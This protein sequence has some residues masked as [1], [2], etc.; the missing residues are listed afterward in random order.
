LK[1]F[2]IF[3]IF[4]TKTVAII[5]GGPAGL[6]AAEE[7][8]SAGH[9]VSV[10]DAMPS[11]GRKFLLAGVGGMNITHAEPAED[12]RARYSANSQFINTLK[13]FDSVAL[14]NWVHGL[15]IETFVG[16]SG[17][18]FP[19]DMKAAP[20]LRAWLHR[21]RGLGVTFYPRHRWLGWGENV[22][23]KNT[24]ELIFSTLENGNTITKTIT[25]DAVVLALGGASWQRL[26]SD[27][28]WVP[29]LREHNITVNELV[30]SNCG[31]DVAWSE[32]LCGQHAGAPLHGVG[33]SCIDL[34]GML[35][36]VLSE[37][38]ISAYGIEGTG[39]YALSKYLREQ[40]EQQGSALLNI[41]LLPDLPL[42]KIVQR[43]NKPREKNSLSNFLR[44]QLHLSP[45]K[46]ALLREL[47]TKQTFENTDL[48]AMAIKKLS[49]TL[50]AT[51]P[52]DE[53]ISSAG[54]VS[55]KDLDA[56][57]MLK[58]IPGVFCAGEMLDW[59][60]PTG[61]YL[62]TGCF[63]SGRTAGFGVVKYLREIN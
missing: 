30:P 20:L 28:A 44:K 41:D 9:L 11:V 14:R 27:G 22:G 15:G 21:L 56:A 10:Y 34:Q 36:S 51:R 2:D 59:D 33:L 12:F 13:Q 47:T 45:A 18:V 54:G 31:F 55:A 4:P 6:M 26:G 23:G 38:I 1:Q 19:M 49:V 48:L 42:D 63:A 5:G 8:A 58:K 29:L 39:I 53:A 50:T 43:L 40:L 7:I 3:D 52:I 16:T 17:R 57:F 32:M 25:A 37:A 60:A 35:R 61:G 46:L 62:L 24:T